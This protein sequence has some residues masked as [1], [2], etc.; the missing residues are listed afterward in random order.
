MIGF[1]LFWFNFFCDHTFDFYC[2][3]L[4]VWK[5]SWLGSFPE[6]TTLFIPF[7]SR[8]FSN[9]LSPRTQNLAPLHFL[10]PPFPQ[11]VRFVFSLLS[12]P[13]SIFDL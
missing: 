9:C 4:A 6:I 10:V 13:L 5:L 3:L 11:I 2:I 8:I 7:N 12:L 1:N